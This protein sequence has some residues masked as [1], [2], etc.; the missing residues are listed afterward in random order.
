MTT[1]LIHLTSSDIANIADVTLSTVSN[2]R[3]RHR[4]FPKPVSGSGS[5][6]RFDAT[7]V[8]QWLTARGRKVK[9]LAADRVL[10][11]VLNQWGGGA[12]VEEIGKFVSALLVWRYVA[13]PDSPGFIV[14]LSPA[15]Q[16]SNLT[17]QRGPT[18]VLTV[19]REGVREF[20]DKTQGEYQLV[21]DDLLKL[22]EQSSR[23][24]ASRSVDGLVDVIN[25]FE[26]NELGA[27]YV[28]FQDRLTQSMHRKFDEYASS[29]ALIDLMVAVSEDIPGP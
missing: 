11:N 22:A 3:S 10:W 28:A 19:L 29:A 20:Y 17:Q 13:D 24:N 12:P 9:D 6:P 23:D 8:R 21:F 2:W 25:S 16:W 4:D 26:S 1:S 14:D 27:V 5:S 15:G 18:G 7:E